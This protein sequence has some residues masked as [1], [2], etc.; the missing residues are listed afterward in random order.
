MNLCG[1]KGIDWEFGTDKAY[2]ATFKM[3]TI[4][5]WCKNKQK[6]KNTQKW[7]ALIRLKE[8]IQNLK[9]Y[10]ILGKGIYCFIRL[11]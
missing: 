4:R 7:I 10:F 9:I 3:D 2:I 1:G 8:K 6:I 11:L 5:N